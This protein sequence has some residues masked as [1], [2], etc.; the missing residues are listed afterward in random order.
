MINSNYIYHYHYSF[1]YNISFILTKRPIGEKLVNC[2]HQSNI[3]DHRRIQEHS[4]N[5]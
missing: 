4:Y 2:G 3:E 1:N 5:L